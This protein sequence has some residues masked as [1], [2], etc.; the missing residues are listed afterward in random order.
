MFACSESIQ[1]SFSNTYKFYLSTKLNIL[2]TCREICPWTPKNVHTH[3]HKENQERR[4]QN[5]LDLNKFILHI[6]QHHKIFLKK[7]TFIKASILTSQMITESNKYH[8]F[9]SSIPNQI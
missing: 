7:S 6:N 9:L 4:V 5:Q 1:S 8:S 3:K 2:W